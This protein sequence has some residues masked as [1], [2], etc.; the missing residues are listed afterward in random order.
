MSF[1]L[2]FWRCF[3]CWKVEPCKESVMRNSDVILAQSFGLRANGPGI[4]NEALAR[5]V[6]KLYHCYSFSLVLQWEIADCLPDLP[7]DGIIRSHRVEG[8]YL[9][10][11]EVLSQMMMICEK[12]DWRKAIIVAHPDHSWRVARTAEKIGF[13]VVVADTLLVPYD[14]ES[15]QWWTRSRWKFLP[16][17]IMA[18]VFCLIHRWI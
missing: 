7:K 16:R 6:D 13:E 1:F 10:T 4:S 8:K 3:F 12:Q 14:K 5:V 17:E 18:R 2:K 15:I 9:D 11:F